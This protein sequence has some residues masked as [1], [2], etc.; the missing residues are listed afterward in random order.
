MVP[1][2]RS[3]VFSSPHASPFPGKG[4]PLLCHKENAWHRYLPSGKRAC[5]TA[6]ALVC[7]WAAVGGGILPSAASFQTGLRPR[8]RA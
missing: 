4:S 8:P 6:Q 7:M 3:L 2:T 5:A 1:W